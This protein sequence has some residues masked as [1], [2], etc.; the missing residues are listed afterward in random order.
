MK[1]LWYVVVFVGLLIW[2]LASSPDPVGVYVAKHH[3]NTID[4]IFVLNGDIYKQ[5][6]YSKA[7]G[8]K[9]FYNEG[10]W[11]YQKGRIRFTDFFQGDDIARKSNYNYASVIIV[12][13]VQLE[14]NFI[15]QPVFDYDEETDTYRYYKVLW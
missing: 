2:F 13:S 8:E 12:F 5:S 14:R 1:K 4:T 3:T 11:S 10:K 15:G 6:I 9:L 7:N